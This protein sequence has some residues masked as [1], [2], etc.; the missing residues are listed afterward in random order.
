[1]GCQVEEYGLCPWAV[2][3]PGGLF[4]KSHC[5]GPWRGREP[6][7][8]AEV[9]GQGEGAPPPQGLLSPAECDVDVI[10]RITLVVCKDADSP[11][12]PLQS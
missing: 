6:Q 8:S 7:K 12:S 2:G 9:V 4:Q 1:M 11:T 10:L 3:S 5:S